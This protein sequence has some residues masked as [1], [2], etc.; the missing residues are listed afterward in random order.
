MEPFRY[1]VFICDQKKPEGVPSCCAHGSQKVI[2]ALRRELGTRGLNDEVQVTT[3]GSL[4]L[5]ENGPNMVVYPEGVWYSH[6]TPEDVREIV[7]S[8]FQNGK[9]VARLV[10]ENAAELKAEIITNRDRYLASLKARDAAGMLP[11]ELD[12][13]IKSF[14]ESRALLTAIELDIFNAVG[15]G[16]TALQIAEKL[17]TDS[18]AT[19]MLLNVLVG[20]EVL[21]KGGEMFVN[22]ATSSRF[23]RE[24]SPDNMRMSLMHSVN[25]WDSWSTLTECVRQGTSVRRAAGVAHD[26]LQTKAFIAAMHRNARERASVVIRAVGLNGVSRMIDLGGGSGAYSIAFAQAKPDLK[27]TLLDVPE[28]LPLTTEYVREAGVAERVTFTP[29]DLRTDKFGGGYDLALLSAI[30]HMFGVEQNKDLLRRAFE[31]LND[32]GRL[33]I[34]EFIL[35]PDRSK[36][37]FAALFSL[38]M[39]VG[40]EKGS[41]YSSDEYT[42]W[43]KA[44]GFRDVKYVRLP[45]PTSLMIATK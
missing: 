4:G 38:H 37:L 40:T 7:E 22:T 3:C 29:G 14:W 8:H 32:G 25:L 34:Q 28:V 45:G 10:R 6:L 33:V 20:M 36:P 11:E 17:G 2:D 24:G 21:K 13:R 35:E 27:V 15:N 1:H 23:F 41:S 39:L 43:L 19:E 31:A 44:V 26:E 9:P 30:C 5:C 16:G 18:R 12:L 42:D